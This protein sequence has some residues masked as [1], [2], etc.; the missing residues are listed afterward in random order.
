MIYRR[1]MRKSLLRIHT[2]IQ[3]DYVMPAKQ[4]H[5]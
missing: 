4:R 5:P 1:T 2:G 3:N